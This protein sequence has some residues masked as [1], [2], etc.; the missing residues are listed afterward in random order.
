MKQLSWFEAVMIAL[1]LSIVGFLSLG[2]ALPVS[3]QMTVQVLG[4]MAVVVA[5]ALVVKAVSGLA[6]K[7]GR[8]KR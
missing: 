8:R 7:L 6:S 3:R 4:I 5:L 2:L 1:V